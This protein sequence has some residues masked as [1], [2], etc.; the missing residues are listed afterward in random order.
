MSVKPLKVGLI[1]LGNMGQN[2]L[3]VLSML[4]SV[5]ISF[6]YDVDENLTNTLA[7]KYGC[8]PSLSLGEDLS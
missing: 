5:E 3:R 7:L 2:H 4:K 1:G 6:I 8:R